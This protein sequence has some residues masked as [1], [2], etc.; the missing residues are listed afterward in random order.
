MIRLLVSDPA[1]VS[2]GASGDGDPPSPLA[3]GETSQTASAASRI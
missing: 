1:F 2:P 3:P